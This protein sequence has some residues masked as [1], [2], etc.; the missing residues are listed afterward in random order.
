MVTLTSVV[1]S[2]SF[3]IAQTKR[4]EYCRYVYV[5]EHTAALRPEKKQQIGKRYVTAYN[6][7]LRCSNNKF[8][9]VEMRK[10][11]SSR[12]PVYPFSRI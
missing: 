8:L 11:R 12:R 2:Y 4:I 9:N 10:C 5:T 7:A 6:D 3:V 1:W